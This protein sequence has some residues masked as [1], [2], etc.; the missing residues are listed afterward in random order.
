M[1]S[2]RTSNIAFLSLLIVIITSCGMINQI[3]EAKQFAFCDFSVN[4]IKIIKLGNIDV[5]EYRDIDDVSL[6][7]ILI[8]GQQ[9]VSD[10]LPAT[11][12]V[13]IKVINNQNKKAAISGLSWQLF[14]KSEE[15][16][17]GELVQ[18]L[19]VLPEQTKDF[20]VVT[21]FNLLKLLKSEDLESILDLILD[22][23]NREKLDKLD[24]AIKFKPFF[25]SGSMVK[26]Y[27][28]YITIRP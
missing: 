16:G 15:Y 4:E 10:K 8:L 21:D 24:I 23:E 6:P 2:I 1:R 18:N 26:E 28:G 17:S 3:N 25:K 5:S 9:L 14:M 13:D 7:D 19:E 20:T 27:P 22:I 11:L 12:S